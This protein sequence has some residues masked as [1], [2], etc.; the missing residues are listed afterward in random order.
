M[1]QRSFRTCDGHEAKCSQRFIESIEGTA[2]HFMI[3]GHPGG[4]QGSCV[5]P[6]DHEEWEAIRRFYMGVRAQNAFRDPNRFEHAANMLGL[7]AFENFL[8]RLQDENDNKNKKKKQKNNED[9]KNQSAPIGRPRSFRREESSN[10][11]PIEWV[12][13]WYL[14][15]Q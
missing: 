5:L 8:K 2:L 12:Q 11:W 6:I 15:Q 9:K 13:E 10:N 4:L 3:C 7:T 1:A 14:E